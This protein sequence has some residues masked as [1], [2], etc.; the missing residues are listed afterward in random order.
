MTGVSRVRRR[1]P[2]RLV[3]SRETLVSGLDP[4]GRG[5]ARV[6]GQVIFIDGALPGERVRYDV[7][8][9]KR[10]H[11]E[12][13]LAQILE[14]SPQRVTPKCAHF[15]RCG[16]CALQHLSG[17]AQVTYKQQD[18]LDKLQYLGKVEVRQ[19]GTPI[20]GPQWGYRRKARLGCKQVPAKGGVLVGFRE[21]NGRLLAELQ[22]CAVLAPQ[23]GELIQ[24][25]RA[26][27]TGLDASRDIAQ[28]EVAV[29]DHQTVLVL[30]NLQPLGETDQQRLRDFAALHDLAIALQ[31]GGPE[32]VTGLAPASLP[33]LS[34]RL[35]EQNLE[36]QFGVLDFVQVN[37]PV[38]QALVSA[39]VEALDPAP[40]EALLDLFC[41]LGNFSLALARRGAAVTG[42]ELSAAMVAR[43]GANAR[44][45][46][47]EN[48][49]FHSA[50]LSDAD[51]NGT[52]L[53]QGWRKLLL[54]PP[55]TG[56]A[57]VIEALHKP[58]PERIVYISCNPATL[59]RDAGVL[60]HQYAYKLVSCT[61]VDMFPQTAHV[62][63]LCVFEL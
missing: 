50:D 58:L 5:V 44:A 38:N 11:A 39:A 36:L 37:G 45:N 51:I 33:T 22:S 59:A 8:K 20:R 1:N 34:Y 21:R 31:P 41:G 24:P 42:L 7:Y 29:A 27:L 23:V 56:A 28:I 14:P 30:R 55:R 53:G 35:R 61:V 63:S 46:G 62:E 54:D 2:E 48:V 15:G 40:G 49:N 12:A 19:L 13:R 25:L 9:R 32:T 52:W 47:L 17:E 6:E 4:S 26:L 10:R 57:A 43:A 3:D 16:G 60:V 18:L